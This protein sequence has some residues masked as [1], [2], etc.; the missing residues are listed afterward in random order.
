MAQNPIRRVSP[1][2][3]LPRRADFIRSLWIGGAVALVFAVVF[4]GT[5]YITGLHSFRV[6]IHLVFEPRIPFV[7]ALA[8]LY[9][10]MGAMFALAPFVLRSWRDLLPLALTLSAETVVAGFFFLMLPV[11]LG[12]PVTPNGTSLMWGI[13]HLA[14]VLNLEYNALPSLHVAFAIT[15]AEVY[16]SRTTTWGRTGFRLWAAGIAVA[17]VLIH[18][19]HL[20]DIVA[21]ALV[22]AIALMVVLPRVSNRAF[23]DMVQVE[24][25]CLRE[26][27]WFVRRH[28]R[29]GL[30]FVAMYSRCLT[31]WNSTRVVRAGYCLLQHL[32][33]V[34]DKDRDV[35][36]DPATYLN[37]VLD[38]IE[39]GRYSRDSIASVLAAFVTPELR[40]RSVG[41]T[42]LAQDMTDLIRIL[43]F[44][45][46]RAE[47]SL[48]LPEA[49]L[50]EHHRR[51]FE[52]SLALTLG[53]S[54]S[55]LTAGDVRALIDALAWCSPMR[56]LEEDLQKGLINV[57]IEV[58]DAAGGCQTGIP[59]YAELVGKP[60]VRSWIEREFDLGLA[61]LDT[62][63]ETLPNLS[64]HRGAV[65]LGLLH[66]ALRRYAKRYART[67][68]GLS[69][70]TNG[71]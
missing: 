45:H 36:V 60:L 19:H 59:S 54:G 1:V 57:P 15:T 52:L 5:D 7:P 64:E 70:S 55:D 12:F 66:R 28:V 56:D 21:G 53:A 13:F 6:H 26:F 69:T 48:L 8:S 16:G 25:V 34:A 61:A 10:S 2:L 11:E 43:R 38:Q 9:L 39:T 24:W 32:D 17:A 47:S 41:S 30:S 50:R 35:G 3:K 46:E 4:A 20:L 42:D 33:D 58:L 71:S 40:Q 51:T 63:E 27:S 37:G 14:D 49:E 18:A 22:A 31:N 67:L 23:L 29:Y 62:F 44:D 68:P 65:A